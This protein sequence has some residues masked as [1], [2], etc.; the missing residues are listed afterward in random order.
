MLDSIDLKNILFLDIETVPMAAS[1]DELP[2]NLK[3]LWNRKSERISS[4]EDETP[5]MLFGKAGIFAEFG[6]IICI[7]VG[8]FRE[9]AFRIKSFFDDDEKKLLSDFITLL[10]SHFNKP[11][12][13]LCAHNGKEFDFPYLARRILINGLKIP[14]ILDYTGKKPWEVPTSIPWKCGNLGIIKIILRLNYWLPYLIF[15]HQRTILPAAM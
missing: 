9:D 1:Y 10:N 7:S 14:L 2:D 5:E 8:C 13:R 12:Y 11:N 3:K 4:N 6:K 15:P